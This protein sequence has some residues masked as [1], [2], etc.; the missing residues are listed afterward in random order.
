MTNRHVYFD[1]CGLLKPSCS[2][3][4][5]GSYKTQYF[6]FILSFIYYFVYLLK[7]NIYK[8]STYFEYF[9]QNTLIIRLCHLQK[10]KV[11]IRALFA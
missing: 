3:K 10:M 6:S 11:S 8:K 7:N 1:G 5:T 4:A 2:L 9:F